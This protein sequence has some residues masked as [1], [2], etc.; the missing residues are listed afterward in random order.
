[1]TPESLDPILAKF[2]PEDPDTTN[3]NVHSRVGQE[4]SNHL[5]NLF[6]AP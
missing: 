3:V 2:S 5:Q 6:I 4:T 1:M